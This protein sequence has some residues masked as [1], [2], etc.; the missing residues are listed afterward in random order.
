MKTVIVDYRETA[1]GKR[2]PSAIRPRTNGKFLQ[3]RHDD[4]EY[5]LFSPREVTPYHSDLLERFCRERGI[6]GSYDSKR[7][8][9]DIRESSWTVEGGGKF[10]IDTVRKYIRLYD[11]SMAYGKF[12]AAG[13]KD[14]VLLVKGLAGYRVMIE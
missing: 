4:T 14:K 11:N 7:K 3:V 9:Y 6:K 2:G 13:L 1:S 8:R 10:D 5:I 12:D